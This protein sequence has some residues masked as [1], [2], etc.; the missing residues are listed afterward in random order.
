MTTTAVLN[1]P[2]RSIDSLA[3]SPELA[4]QHKQSVCGVSHHSEH[5]QSSLGKKLL[6]SLIVFIVAMLLSVLILYVARPPLVLVDLDHFVIP[7]EWP[8]SQQKLWGWSALFAFVIA[9]IVLIIA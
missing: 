6:V 4:Q 9:V 5:G 3:P 8:I 7:S 2:K 1:T